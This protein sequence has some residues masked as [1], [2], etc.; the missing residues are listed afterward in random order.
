M[1]LARR[2]GGLTRFLPSSVHL[3]AGLLVLGPLFPARS[4]VFAGRMRIGI[5]LWAKIGTMTYS[6]VSALALL[7]PL[8]GLSA[9]SSKEGE[10]LNSTG[11]AGSLPSGGN[12]GIGGGGLDASGGV[13]ATGGGA[14]SGGASGVGGD[15]SA[16]GGASTGGTGSG[17]DA[18]GGTASGGQS[19]TGARYPFPQNH[20]SEHCVF[21]TAYQNSDVQA[22]YQ[23]WKTKVV[24]SEGAS[25]HLRIKKPD[26]GSV[27]GST[28]SEGMGYGLLLSVYM[29]EQPVFDELWKYVLLYLNDN[30]LMD[31]EVSPTG[32]V[33][34]LGA[35]LDGD[36]D[37]AWAL[38]M[39]DRQWGGQGS[40]DKTYL[41]YAI[42]LIH[43]MWDFEV[44][45]TRG[46]MPLAGDTWGDVDITNIS[47]FAPA[48]YRVFGQVAG[49]EAEWN[50]A[51]DTSYSIL[52]KSLNATSGNANNGL[53]PAW[54]DSAGTPVVAFDGAPTHY[55]ND[56]SRTPFRIGQDYCYYGEPRALAYMEKITSFFVGVGVDN[57]V[58][59]YE[60][61]GTPRPDFGKNGVGSASF[62]GPAAVGASY[63]VSNQAFLDEA[64]A[65]LASR[66]LTAGTIY[67]QASWNALS[68]L[69]L[70]GGFYEFPAAN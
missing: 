34:G 42:D 29:D 60:L 69:M 30:G 4:G 58:D 1:L 45:H 28:V 13:G 6:Q 57:I 10:P 11:G 68:I 19:Q 5:A 54:C 32:E 27:I 52:N 43:A 67:Y 35:A 46:D 41:A 7:V 47:Y 40:L 3:K 9:C 15:P 26:S 48:Y 16:V 64:Y 2:Q 22:A 66:T 38:I 23:D 51:I 53:V 39:A 25:G 14:P 44:D 36:E 31:W 37:M 49:M 50:R 24:T 20:E 56:S 59:G 65:A 18:A 63:G 33:I 61:N 21:P 17:G 12:S 62:V 70:S 8:I 55:Q